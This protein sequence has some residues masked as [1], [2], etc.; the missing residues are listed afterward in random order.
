MEEGSRGRWEE[1]GRKKD[2][3]VTVEGRR[4]EKGGERG[5]RKKGE[6]NEGARKEERLRKGGRRG[7]KRERGR[8]RGRGGRCPCCALLLPGNR[9]HLSW[10]TINQ[11]VN[12]VII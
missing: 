8:E 6:S 1:G 2:S 10:N 5:R 3:V 9:L 7:G 12:H 11:P 4:R